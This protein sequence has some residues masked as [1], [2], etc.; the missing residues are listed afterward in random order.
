[1][2]TRLI[3]FAA[4]LSVTTTAVSAQQRYDCALPANHSLQLCIDACAQEENYSKQTCVDLRASNDELGLPPVS[5]GAVAGN[6]TGL[7]VAGV[8]GL[9]AIAAAS[10]GGSSD[11]ATSTPGTN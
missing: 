1:M 2:L 10:S 8:V 3:S 9:L 5:E 11:T 4:V 6:N 7:I